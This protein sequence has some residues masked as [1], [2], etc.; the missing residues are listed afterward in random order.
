M[1]FVERLLVV[2]REG[3]TWKKIVA[4]SL[5]SSMRAPTLIIVF[6]VLV[7]APLFFLW[8]PVISS[9]PWAITLITVVVPRICGYIHSQ[10]LTSSFLM[11]SDDVT[12][13]PNFRFYRIF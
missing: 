2:F 12:K 5:V 1:L 4:S 10:L 6:Q 3:D 9:R 13:H 11:P 7:V 8:I